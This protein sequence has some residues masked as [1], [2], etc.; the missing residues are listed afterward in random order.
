MVALANNDIIVSQDELQVVEIESNE[1]E[2]GISLSQTCPLKPDVDAAID[3]KIPKRIGA[4]LPQAQSLYNEDKLYLESKENKAQF[5]T[6]AQLLNF[7]NIGG[8]GGSGEVR[9][10]SS[11]EK[12]SSEGLVDIYTIY[13]TDNT[14]TT[15]TVTNGK[16]GA[17]GKDGVNGKDGEN[18]KDGINGISATHSWNGTTLTITSASGTSS[19]DLKGEKGDKGEKGEQGER[20]IQ[21]E[22]GEKGE[23]GIQG[24]KGDTGEQGIQGIQ[25]DRGED[26]KDG[27]NGA[28]G[29]GISKIEK[30]NT[31]GKIDTYTIYYT[32]NTTSAFVVTNGQDGQDASITEAD[33]S[34]ITALVKA[35]IPYAPAY[36]VETEAQTKVMDVINALQNFGADISQFNIVS[37]T[38]YASDIYGLQISHY[39]GNVYRIVG[40]NLRTGETTSVT[41]DW[42]NKNIGDFQV[43]FVAHQLKQD[44][45]LNTNSKD[46]VGAINEVNENVGELDKKIPT[47]TSQLTNDSGFLTQH[48]SL[49]GYAKTTDHYTKTESD[50]KYQPKGNYLT[51]HQDISGKADKSSAETWT[52]TLEDG[53]TITKKVVLV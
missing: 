13:F 39:G 11:I 15:Y 22:R 9:G 46:V 41:N 32:N 43:T 23:Q 40:I 30:T 37:F 3:S 2:G 1:C 28:D 53:S 12:T 27:T 36:T 50:N 31:N 20:G 17:N 51:S 7:L 14:I 45:E 26:G 4:N 19:T 10:I 47:K 44:D 48:Q 42:S 34:N 38:G 29:V 16:N 5:A 33:I 24:K 52:F 35:Q 25:G 6:L 49:A 8:S 18:G 21:G